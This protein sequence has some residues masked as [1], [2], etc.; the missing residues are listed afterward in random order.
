MSNRTD[1]STA[2]I[3]AQQYSNFIL[4]NLH[5]GLLPDMFTRDV[6]DFASGTTL[7]IKTI[8]TV[9][10]QE[11]AENVPLTFNAIDTG[12]VT[13]AITEYP[14]D[15][16]YITDD[17]RQDGA[18]VEALSAARGMES[19]RALQEFFETKFLASADA[20]QTK[21]GNVNLVNAR[22]HRWV[23]GGA[24]GT[25]RNMTLSDIIALKLSFDKANVPQ[26]GR[27]LIVDPIVE[28][29]VNS[30]TNLVN[31]SNNPMFEGIV[32]TGFAQNHKFVRNIFGF[33]IWTS[34]YLPT[35]TATEVLNASS[36]NLANDTAE[37]G[38]V[39]NI[40]M[41]VSD[42]NVRPIMRAWRSQP[43]V[44]GWRDPEHRRDNFQTYARLGFGAQ[45]VDSLAAIITSPSTY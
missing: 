34:N 33:D 6:S 25:S 32:T 28:A 39:V 13:L 11:G 2:F 26:N 22:P 18:Q 12:T 36:Y 20:A 43:A 23:A 3:E 9:T 45:R 14:G 5:D 44:E 1:N 41:C 24:S 19:T 37:V 17:L 4:N 35:L 29:T 10:I 38:D 21:T 16:W 42:D 40:A 27:I 30:L 15:A 31:V 8:G 7:N